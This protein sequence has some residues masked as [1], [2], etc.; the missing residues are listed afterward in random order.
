M[1]VGL[2]VNP[3][4]AGFAAI[5][6]MPAR[7]APSAN[8]LT[9]RLGMALIALI[10]VPLRE[11]REDPA[12]GLGQRFYRD[13]SRLGTLFAVAVVDEEIRTPRRLAR[14]HVPPPLAHHET[15][16]QLDAEFPRAPD[17]HPPLPP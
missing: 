16:L 2:V 12:R 1:S 13:I 6:L 17:R 14:P 4:I 9:F 5:S 11:S 8:S 3:L 7:S 15:P 10:L